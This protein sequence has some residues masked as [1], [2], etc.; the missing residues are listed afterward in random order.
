MREREREA[1]GSSCQSKPTVNGWAEKASSPPNPAVLLMFLP[2]TCPFMWLGGRKERGIL[3]N[4][5]LVSRRCPRCCHMHF[6][7]TKP[8][9][10]R[11]S[12]SHGEGRKLRCGRAERLVQGQ[13]SLTLSELLSRRPLGG[14][15][16]LALTAQAHSAQLKPYL[17]QEPACPQA[18]PILPFLIS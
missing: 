17:P 3:K 5:L 18:F 6:I 16:S 10:L 11:R 2:V 15:H 12:G 13:S 4:G 14:G 8:L 9:Q 1:L 7:V